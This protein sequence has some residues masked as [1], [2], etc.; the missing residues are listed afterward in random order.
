ML[1][2]L[3]LTTMA[4]AGNSGAGDFA[5]GAC[6]HFAL[7]F[8]SRWGRQALPALPPTS[9]YASYPVLDGMPANVAALKHLHP[10]AILEA[11]QE[12]R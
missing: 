9:K 5:H 10:Q 7:L 3:L 2:T 8:A 6:R 11:F 4:S 12:V 1:V